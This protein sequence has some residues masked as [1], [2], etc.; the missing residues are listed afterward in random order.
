MKTTHTTT[1]IGEQRRSIRALFLLPAAIA[2]GLLLGQATSPAQ[3]SSDSLV[4][5]KATG[6]NF[7]LEGGPAYMHVKGGNGGDHALEGSKNFYGGQ[8]AFGMRFDKHNKAQIEIGV[9]AGSPDTEWGYADLTSGRYYGKYTFNFMSVPVLASYSYCIQLDSADRW[10]LRLTPMLGMMFM[11]LTEDF[12]AKTV[13]AK[14]EN[15]SKASIAYGAG[16]G[17]TCHINKRFYVDASLRYVRAGTFK[18]DLPNMQPELVNPY[19]IMF[20]A[21]FGW[22]F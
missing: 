19:G 15:S 8:I 18:F 7:Y 10:E 12:E 14:T 22:K 6:P 17:L 5:P 20:N 1:T 11:G 16:A 3:T 13:R 21:S 2:A 9:L 4:M